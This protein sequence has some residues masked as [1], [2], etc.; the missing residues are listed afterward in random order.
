MRRIPRLLFAEQINL[1]RLRIEAMLPDNFLHVSTTYLEDTTEEEFKEALQNNTIVA[2]PPNLLDGDIKEELTPGARDR[3]R[4]NLRERIRATHVI[5]LFV[6]NKKSTTN[7]FDELTKLCK[8]LN[9]E[10]TAV[11][12]AV[13]CILIV[14]DR[15]PDNFEKQLDDLLKLKEKNGLR[16]LYL[17]TET[18]EPGAGEIVHARFV[19]PLAVAKLLTFLGNVEEKD[20]ENDSCSILAWRGINF[21][22]EINDTEVE[23]TRSKMMHQTI[24]GDAS[25][26]QNI[27][28]MPDPGKMTADPVLFGSKENADVIEKIIQSGVASSEPRQESQS[29]RDV[30]DVSQTTEG[31]A[32]LTAGW[33]TEV[34]KYRVGLLNG[35]ATHLFQTA[36]SDNSTKQL[37]H[38]IKYAHSNSHNINNIISLTTPTVVT[39]IKHRDSLI[40]LDTNR[41]TNQADSVEIFMAEKELE[42]A[43]KRHTSPTERFLIAFLTI[44]FVGGLWSAI[45]KAFWSI[46]PVNMIFISLTFFSAVVLG[47]FAG[48][49]IPFIVEKKKLDAARDAIHK[50]ATDDFNKRKQDAIFS[51]IILTPATEKDKRIDQFSAVKRAR[52]LCERVKYILEQAIEEGQVPT[53]RLRSLYNN[54]VPDEDKNLYN[55]DR[56]EYEKSATFEIPVHLSTA[57][58]KNNGDAN[59][60]P[61]ASLADKKEVEVSDINVLATKWKETW[62]LLCKLDPDNLGHFPYSKSLAILRKFATEF[63]NDIWNQVIEDRIKHVGDLQLE[64]N[65]KDILDSRKLLSVSVSGK[66]ELKSKIFYRGIKDKSKS[67]DAALVVAGNEN[68]DE[69]ETKKL[70]IAD[71]KLMTMV[72]IYQECR[73]QFKSGRFEAFGN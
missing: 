58:T 47:C 21:G 29:I 71:S 18:L 35:E 62:S 67:Y 20:N 22:P 7:W 25:S 12:W 27:E 24:F 44:L 41:L 66:P 16:K 48:A 40:K 54:L 59:N 45:T 61:A 69:V 60:N 63:R 73:I 8:D 23:L 1:E 2:L 36:Q 46:E 68:K 3:Y 19:W 57:D 43:L 31:G 15:L 26:F 17:M 55:E 72:M 51:K 9:P 4:K 33:N 70:L 14:E 42:R 65:A 5:K 34:E 32:L 49:Y 53:I 30:L 56:R 6:L 11:E 64:V 50:W 10:N 38:I 52:L 28:L 13:T 39:E 37:Q